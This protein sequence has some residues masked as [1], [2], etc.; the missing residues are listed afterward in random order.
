[1]VDGN[2]AGSQE[3]YVHRLKKATKVQGTGARIN[4]TF[5]MM[6]LK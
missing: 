3:F 1:M 4:F 5:R 6:N 2:A